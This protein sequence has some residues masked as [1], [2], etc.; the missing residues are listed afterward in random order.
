MTSKTFTIIKREYLSR[1]RKKSF[2]VMTIVGP[3]LLAALMIVPVFIASMSDS[4]YH[5]GIVDD[6]RL[7]YTEFTD[8]NNV[9]FTHINTDIDSAIELMK[10]DAF[11]AIIHIPVTAFH[12]PSTLRFFSQ[13]AINMNAK[14]YAERILQH[15]FENM[16]LAQAGIDPEVIKATETKVSIQAIRLLKDG[17]EQSDY[18]EVSMG[19]GIFAGILIY[20]FVFLFGAQV[21]RGVMEEK[22]NRI[23]EIIV[24]SVK[25]FQLMMGKITGIALVGLTQFLIWIVLT[26]AIVSTVRTAMPEAFRF[27]PHE[28]V[29]ITGTQSLNPAELQQQAQTVQQHNT[30]VGQVMEALSAINFTVMIL[31][32][33][34]YFLGGYLL[35]AALFAAIGSA[36]D[37][38]ADTQQ[39]MLPITIPLVFSIVMAQLVMNNPSGSVA[40]WMSIIPFTSPIIMMVRI[41]FG[42]PY[43]DLW[44]S[45]VLLILGFLATTWLAAKIYRTGIL[46]YGKK[47]SY[48]EIWKWIRIKS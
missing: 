4:E 26:F 48:K 39:F 46:M 13:K 24:S 6:T 38:E 11:D 42:V 47:I 15:E 34:F 25:P 36:V 7:F 19:L 18:P 22:S 30:A 5:I 14:I 17:H 44:I 35:Y 2:I 29:Y 41:P 43:T 20:F 45:A 10:R 37:N 28:Q 12:A 31:A 9:N 23:V 32:F 33:I 1:V 16:K 27:T 3:L 8:A 21:M 40:F